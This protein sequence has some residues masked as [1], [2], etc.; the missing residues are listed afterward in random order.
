MTD[1]PPESSSLLSHPIDWTATAAAIVITALVSGV[2]VLVL[3]IK[4]WLIAGMTVGFG[5]FSPFP[6]IDRFTRTAFWVG[7]VTGTAA[8]LGVWLAILVESFA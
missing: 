8:W 3:P 2:L 7:A 6:R 1:T 5:L 4:L